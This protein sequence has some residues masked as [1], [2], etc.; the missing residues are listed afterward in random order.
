MNVF[1][2]NLEEI[3]ESDISFDIILLD[4]FSGFL[5]RKEKDFILFIIYKSLLFLLFLLYLISLNNIFV[6]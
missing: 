2:L 5:F 3:I 1:E 6:M 4:L